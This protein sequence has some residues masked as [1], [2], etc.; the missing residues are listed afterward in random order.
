MSYHAVTN[1]P[2][3]YFPPLPTCCTCVWY[4][5][6]SVRERGASVDAVFAGPVLVAG[7]VRHR[8]PPRDLG[9]V[10][11][12][13][14]APLAR[15][16]QNI[17][18][19]TLHGE[20]DFFVV[21]EN[22]NVTDVGRVVHSCGIDTTTLSA[23]CQQPLQP[24]RRRAAGTLES[25]EP[26]R[27]SQH[28]QVFGRNP[29]DP[30]PGTVSA[31]RQGSA[32]RSLRVRQ[33]CARCPIRRSPHETG[34]RRDETPVNNPPN[35]NAPARTIS[36]EGR[37]RR[38]LSPECQQPSHQSVNNPSTAAQPGIRHSLCRNASRNA[39]DQS[40]EIPS[41]ASRSTILGLFDSTPR[42]R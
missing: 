3:Q 6:G 12:C 41:G 1:S 7:V 34:R 21:S 8:S 32:N 25:V 15:S 11:D 42:I 40:G 24:I 33:P 36:L 5:T 37:P 10:T 2:C 28:R 26:Q 35:V 31:H 4:L 14:E 18:I 19:R 30:L 23:E 38:T 39:T 9:H 29:V 27:F 17:D 16:W 20:V 22:S 13:V